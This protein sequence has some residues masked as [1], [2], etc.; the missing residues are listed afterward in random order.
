MSCFSRGIKG[1]SPL[2]RLIER[3][4]GWWKITKRILFVEEERLGI[5]NLEIVLFLEQ[6][7]IHEYNRMNGPDTRIEM[8][9]GGDRLVAQS[10]SF[11]TKGII[12][13]DTHPSLRLLSWRGICPEEFQRYWS[14]CLLITKRL[15]L[16]PTY[17]RKQDGKKW[18]M[19][20]LIGDNGLRLDCA[21][22]VLIIKLLISIKRWKG[23]GITDKREVIL[24]QSHWWH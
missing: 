19:L 4:S 18:Q 12:F 1:K 8:N 21:S 14:R 22:F 2:I 16:L 23:D 17:F 13:K 5:Y 9:S 15:L 6:K 10:S 24:V 11:L 3:V 7:F 20:G